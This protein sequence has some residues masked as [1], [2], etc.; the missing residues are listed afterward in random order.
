MNR[1]VVIVAAVAVAVVIVVSA[2]FNVMFA[3]SLGTTPHEKTGFVAAA[4]AFD[5]LKAT[6]LVFGGALFARR[7]WALGAVTVL[8]WAGC[9][10]WSSASAIGFA[11]MTRGDVVA[12]RTGD[13]DARRAAESRV[14]RIEAAL[15]AVP[16]HRPAGV[17]EPALVSRAGV[18]PGT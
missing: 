17:I 7:K 18:D 13:A 12:S 4:L 2:A 5:A 3:A 14:R 16:S 9:L 15:A 10:A 11:A 1:A 6:L 8:L